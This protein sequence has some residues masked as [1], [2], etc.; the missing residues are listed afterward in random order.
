MEW[1]VDNVE[2]PFEL[3]RNGAALDEVN[4]IASDASTMLEYL[5]LNGQSGL[6][7]CFRGD[8]VGLQAHDLFLEKWGLRAANLPPAA[9]VTS[10]SEQIILVHPTW[11][12]FGLRRAVTYGQTSN[13]V[14]TIFYT[15]GVVETLLVRDVFPIV[16]TAAPDTFVR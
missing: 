7:A 13:N 9:G 6:V 14:A 1:P 15:W 8:D 11:R 10:D 5:R 2:M 4:R 12:G 3:H 16:G